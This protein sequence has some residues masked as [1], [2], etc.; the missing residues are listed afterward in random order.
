VSNITGFEGRGRARAAHIHAALTANV[1]LVPHSALAS[2]YR[3][4][5][6]RHAVRRCLALPAVPFLRLLP[7]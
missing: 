6:A 7:P 5:H 2:R 1:A 4:T 3:T